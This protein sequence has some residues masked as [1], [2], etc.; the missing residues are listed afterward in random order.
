MVGINIADVLLSPLGIDLQQ[1]GK[2][3]KAII[4]DVYQT[5]TTNLEFGIYQPITIY[6]S[7]P[8]KWIIFAEE[9]SL[10]GCNNEIIIPD[11]QIQQKLELGENVIEFTPTKTGIITY[12]CWMVMISSKITVN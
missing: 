8:L 9:G 5:V 1:D 12:T 10:N 2:S 4:E 6:A 3:K 11:H 7:V